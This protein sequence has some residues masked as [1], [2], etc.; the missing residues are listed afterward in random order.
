MGANWSV[1]GSGL[2][3][4]YSYTPTAGVPGTKS[5]GTQ[6]NAGRTGYASFTAVDDTAA[7]IGFAWPT[8]LAPSRATLRRS[9][10]IPI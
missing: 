6:N 10:L 3:R 5:V 8:L 4:T 9:W 2:T 7:F 1:S